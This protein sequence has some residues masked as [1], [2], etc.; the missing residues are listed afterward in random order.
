M[1]TIQCGVCGKIIEVEK[2]TSG[3]YNC[4][5]CG[6]APAAAQPTDRGQDAHALFQFARDLSIQEGDVD[7]AGI[8]LVALKRFAADRAELESLRATYAAK[9]KQ[10]DVFHQAAKEFQ[11]RAFKAEAKVAELEKDNA[12]FKANNRYQRGFGD[13]EKSEWAKTGRIKK[14][15][16]ERD[17]WKAKAE[18]HRD[19][20]ITLLDAKYLDPNCWKGCKSLVHQRHI[21]KLTKALVAYRSAYT[22]GGHSAPHDCFATGPLT[23]DTV[24]DFVRCPG[25]V[26]ER[27]FQQALA[28]DVAKLGEETP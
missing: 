14:A 26:A 17:G 4:P 7:Q 16:A 1:T 2:N 11:E 20:G 5:H 13:G 22:P 24:T 12:D 25:C 6:I 23:G 19:L 9:E 3:F 21:E 15:E 27:L 8:Y 10:C 18:H 28:P